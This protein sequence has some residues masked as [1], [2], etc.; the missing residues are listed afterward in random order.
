VAQNGTYASDV[1]M[2]DIQSPTPKY[3][4][5][6]SIAAAGTSADSNAPTLQNSWSL[7]LTRTS[8]SGG[9]G[10]YTVTFTDQG[11][12]T[13]GSTIVADINPL[14]VATS[15]TTGTTGS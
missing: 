12:D 9:Y 2:L 5:M 10:P 15:G 1:S 11:Y 8:P 4:T 7:T 14:A 3:F 13:T 6:G